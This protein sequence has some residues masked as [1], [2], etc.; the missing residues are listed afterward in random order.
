MEMCQLTKREKEVLDKLLVADV[1]TAAQDL[2]VRP[3]T[4]YVIRGRVRGK[5]EQCRDMLK[6]M[7]K[8]KRVLGVSTRIR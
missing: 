6:L 5:I 1:Q 3:S 2:G 4:I 8:Y 7:K